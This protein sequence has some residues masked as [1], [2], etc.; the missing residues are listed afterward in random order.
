MPTFT[1]E[2]LVDNDALP[3]NNVSA[4]FNIAFVA[5]SHPVVTN[6]Q[7]EENG[8]QV[9][10]TW[11][12]PDLSTAAPEAS[13][14]DFESY[15]GF[16]TVLDNFTMYDADRGN[17]AGFAGFDMPLNRTPQ[18]YF[19]MSSYDL[20]SLYT[21][22]HNSL[23]AM[24]TTDEN[25]RPI[26]ND[27]WLIS[28][29][30]Y[31]GRQ[32]IGFKACSQSIGYGYETFEVYASQ[33]SADIADFEKVMM[34]T[35]VGEEWEQFYVTLPAGTRYF[36]IRCTSND[37]LLFTLDDITYAAKGD[38]QP[39]QLIGYNVYRNGVQLNA[40]PVTATTYATARELAGDDYFVTAVYDLGESTASNILHLG[41][42]GI[43]EIS[44]DIPA[45]YYDL[46]GL[47]INPANL[48]PGIY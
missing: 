16:A 37:C 47:R 34:E 41:V 7:G 3:E 26:R 46:R 44:A 21:I 29:E 45:E 24:A 32:T 1:V 19:V 25:R 13:L 20:E 8:S 28:P 10:L 33:G 9:I 42:D 4:P 27:D 2:V 23:F 12:A 35:A 11:D 5:P 17:I 38:P 18:A 14:E 36:A 48:T 39:M 22:G 30:L 43:D 31:G 40:E 6:L 15:E